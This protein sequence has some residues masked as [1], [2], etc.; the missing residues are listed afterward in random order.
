[1]GGADPAAG[2]RHGPRRR[3]DLA[4][5]LALAQL[6]VQRLAGRALREA[7]DA[8]AGPRVPGLVAR[9]RARR[10]DAHAGLVVPDLAGRAVELHLA[11]A[12]AGLEVQPLTLRAHHRVVALDRVGRGPG[13]DATLR[14]RL[15]ADGARVLEPAAG[16]VRQHRGRPDRRALGA[17]ALDARQRRDDGRIDVRLFE[18]LARL[19]GDHDLGVLVDH[20]GAGID[21]DLDASAA[22]PLRR[23]RIL[24]ERR[25]ED[26][27]R[28]Q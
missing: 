27:E 8:L 24:H 7:A 2:G 1:M 20:L 22:A 14:G 4:D 21:V 10:A 12:H 9:A 18:L 23:R 11:L 13:S 15:H 19:R 5:R 3:I 6:A 28:E 25:R 26:A 17:Q 16:H